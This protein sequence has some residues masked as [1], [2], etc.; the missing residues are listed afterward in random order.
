[1]EQ[2]G[3][4]GD[5]YLSPDIVFSHIF[6]QQKCVRLDCNYYCINQYLGFA[7]PGSCGLEYTLE[8]TGNNHRQ[9]SSNYHHYHSYEKRSGR[10]FWWKFLLF[11]ALVYFILCKTNLKNV[12]RERVSRYFQPDRPD[13]RDRP[14]DPSA[15]PSQ[16]QFKANNDY[17]QNQSKS[18]LM[19]F[20]YLIT[21]CSYCINFSSKMKYLPC[22]NLCRSFLCKTKSDCSEHSIGGSTT[23]LLLRDEAGSVEIHNIWTRGQRQLFG[24]KTS[25]SERFRGRRLR[26][27]SGHLGHSSLLALK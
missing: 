21:C 23:R 22:F 11:V 17:C 27:C 12:I 13:F 10:G 2:S 3:R 14:P 26:S 5:L 20:Q 4:F 24:A 8:Y 9:S 7:F 1:M 18:V 15:P 6:T 16:Q 19:K 25:S